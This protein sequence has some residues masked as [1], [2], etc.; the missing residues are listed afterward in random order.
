MQPAAVTIISQTAAQGG[1]QG[2]GC[3]P[4]EYNPGYDPALQ[5][6]SYPATYTQPS[7]Y[8]PVPDGTYPP[9]GG[10]PDGTQPPAGGYPAYPSMGGGTLPP[11]YPAPGGA[12]PA[13]YPP[14]QP[15]PTQPP[16][17]PPPY[18]VAPFN[19]PQ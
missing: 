17:L 15:Y 8:P 10:Y 2:Y 1:Q 9:P 18:P 16:D 7:P 6:A 12:P 3:D 4:L 14:Q 13:D 11:S 19:A 5:G